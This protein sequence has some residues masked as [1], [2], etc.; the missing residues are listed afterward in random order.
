MRRSV[1]VVFTL[2]L[3]AIY[4]QAAHAQTCK[5]ENWPVDTSAS[6]YLASGG[7]PF[8]SKYSG[9]CT[10]FAWGRGL[11]LGLNVYSQ[12]KKWPDA[13]LWPVDLGLPIEFTPR[14]NSFAVWDDERHGHV[15]F[16]EKVEGDCIYFTEANIETF[17]AGG[18]YDGHVKVKSRS[19]FETRFL[20]KG[21]PAAKFLGYL[22]L[23]AKS[24][25]SQYSN[26]NSKIPAPVLVRLNPTSNPIGQFTI[27]LYGTGFQQQAKIVAQGKD[28]SSDRPPV[29]VID[30]T[31]LQAVID[32]K[33]AGQFTVSVR[34][35]DGQVSQG[36]PIEIKP[37]VALIPGSPTGNTGSL[38]APVLQN[39]NPNRHAV[40]QFAIDLYG[41]GFQQGAK[42]L[43]QGKDWSSD[44]AAV[45]YLGDNHLKVIIS[46]PNPAQFSVSVKNPDGQISSAYPFE[47]IASTGA[48]TPSTNTTLPNGRPIGNSNS[49]I[50]VSPG[51][52][53]TISISP[54]PSST[55]SRQTNSSASSSTSSQG[56]L[57]SPLSNSA[58]HSASPN[59]STSNVLNTQSNGQGSNPPVQK[60]PTSGPS[61]Q[62]YNP[63]ITNAVPRV[64]IP[65][66]TSHGVEQTNSSRPNP[67]PKPLVTGG[68]QPTAN[69]PRNSGQT[70]TAGTHTQ[71]VS[72]P[73]APTAGPV[74]ADPIHHDVPRTQMPP[75]NNSPAPVIRP[76]APV[77]STP[78]R[79][80][81]TQNT[82]L[83]RGP[84]PTTNMPPAAPQK[85]VSPP[86]KPVPPSP[87][88]SA[89][90]KPSPPPAQSPTPSQNNN[91]RKP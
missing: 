82:Q 24:T 36:L 49:T 13:R 30:S 66:S 79:P 35:P 15:A 68:P 16:V 7:N 83:P 20:L 81:T 23:D 31:H 18:G 19:Q 51:T 73:M 4:C 9:Q 88:P 75:Q 40:G 70:P 58:G 64:N 89:Q 86:P 29:T 71:T 46:A 32:S 77:P 69:P 76:P 50:P 39:I 43:A 90:Q 52:N 8:A 78:N 26:S 65:P 60:P 56:G 37:E 33:N 28:W 2:L 45:T 21:Q 54:T 25:A 5:Q 62:G 42:L 61:S 53:G 14:A 10:W 17:P 12:S 57:Q 44:K 6:S 48:G 85:P 47:V 22:Y 67:Q 55:D 63:G 80:S 27:D 74:H 1:L 38:A 72:G 11:Q 87:Q 41:S 3:V 34:N 91:K 84:S 59:P